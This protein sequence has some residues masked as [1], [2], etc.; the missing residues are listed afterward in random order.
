M[1]KTVKAKETA[2]SKSA[3]TAK[4]PSSEARKKAAAAAKL[5][6]KPKRPKRERPVVI[7]PLFDL[8]LS[9]NLDRDF[10]RV[11]NTAFSE[12]GMAVSEGFQATLAIP[13]DA[14]KKARRELEKIG[15][16]F[17]KTM[18]KAVIAFGTRTLNADAI[19]LTELMAAKDGGNLCTP[20]MQQEMPNNAIKRHLGLFRN[21]LALLQGENPDLKKFTD[22]P[23][24]LES[25]FGSSIEN[26]YFISG[27]AT[28]TPNF[29]KPTA[30]KVSYSFDLF[31]K[32][33]KKMGMRLQ[34]SMSHDLSPDNFANELRI[35]VPTADA[36]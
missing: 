31:A 17:S 4:K 34:F 10:Q 15:K 1:A 22:L 5:A 25:Q 32:R 24:K 8:S 7:K 21:V 20:P 33:G 19:K 12:C 2:P 18:A 35:E 14:D 11:M 23:E 3:T 27:M 30:S 9:V 6:E 28:F 13:T 36:K 26:G 29:E 16:T